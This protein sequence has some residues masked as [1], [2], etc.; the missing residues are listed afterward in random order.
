M[1]DNKLHDIPQSWSELTF[2]DKVAYIVTCAAFTIGAALSIAGLVIP[3]MGEVHP[4]VITLVGLFLSF[5]GALLGI[6]HHFE[7][8][9]EKFKNETLSS[10]NQLKQKNDKHEV[11]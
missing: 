10:L 7:N 8:E 4:S 5:C 9:L 1:E 6:S 3:P 11:L 2:R